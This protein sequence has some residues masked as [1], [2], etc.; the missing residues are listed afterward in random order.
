VAPLR[1][2]LAGMSEAVE[3]LFVE[4]FVAQLAIEAFNE[5][6]LLGRVRRDKVPSD[7]GL[8]LPF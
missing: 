4:S 3:D 1:Q 2:H 8:V 7:T 6:V 5:P